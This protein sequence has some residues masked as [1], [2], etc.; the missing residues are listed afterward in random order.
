MSPEFVQKAKAL[1]NAMKL[2]AAR[3]DDLAAMS[4]ELSPELATRLEDIVTLDKALH[5]MWWRLA[6]DAMPVNF[7]DGGRT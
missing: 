7:P 1:E 6:N 5:A 3:R 4:G 2:K